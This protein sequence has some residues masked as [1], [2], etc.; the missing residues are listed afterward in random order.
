MSYDYF[1]EVKKSVIT[2]IPKH[3]TPEQYNKL[4]EEGYLKIDLEDKFFTMIK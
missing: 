1:D 4:S 2:Q 3:Y